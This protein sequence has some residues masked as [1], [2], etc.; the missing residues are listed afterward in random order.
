MFLYFQDYAET[1]MNELLGWYGYDK[2][3]SADTQHLNLQ[4]FTDSQKSIAGETE[5]TCKGETGSGEE[6]SV[7]VGDDDDID[8][9]DDYLS[10]DSEFEA[11]SKFIDFERICLYFVIGRSIVIHMIDEIQ[12]C[13]QAQIYNSLTYLL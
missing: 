5:S 10:D 3:D 1:T 4:Q 12:N 9:F 11:L 7:N 2:V 8:D 13:D 6:D